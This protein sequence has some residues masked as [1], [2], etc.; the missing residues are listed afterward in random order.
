MTQANSLAARA[1]GSRREMLVRWGTD[2]V[3]SCAWLYALLKLFVFDVDLW[4]LRRLDPKL[5]DW[6][7]YRAIGLV[8]LLSILWW[9]LENRRMALLVAKIAFF[10]LILLFWRFPYLLFRQG[11]WNLLIASLHA[12]FAVASGSKEALFTLSVL[13]L[14]GTFTTL[15]ETVFLKITGIALL[16]LG[17]VWIYVLRVWGLVKPPAYYAWH[18]SLFTLARTRLGSI[19]KIPEQLDGRQYPDLSPAQSTQW[20]YNLQLSLLFRNSALFWS[21]KL[22]G[23]ISSGVTTVSGILIALMLVI[24]TVVVFALANY[25]LWRLDSTQF[26]TVTPNLADFIFYSF[27]SL[28]FNY[29]PEITPY[30]TLAKALWVSQEVCAIFITAVFFGLLFSQKSERHVAEVRR[31]A[32]ALRK[33]SSE[34]EGLIRVEYRFQSTEE[35]ISELRHL[36]SNLADFLLKLSGTFKG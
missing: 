13:L 8:V 16:L 29:I 7:S 19:F 9:W 4:L 2:L 10:P 27:N 18:A 33:E 35:A 5:T 36:K 15:S 14:G 3:A 26:Q 11:S 31:A 34:M 20:L 24:Q 21:D 32:N 17:L 25:G 1:T 6:W 23:Y 28:V 12:V 22:T 30:G